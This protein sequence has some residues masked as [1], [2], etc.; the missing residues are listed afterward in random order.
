MPA[1]NSCSDKGD[2]SNA[3]VVAEAVVLVFEWVADRP[4]SPMHARDDRTLR[5]LS[6]G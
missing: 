1:N 4:V 5:G 3:R 6:P 2:L